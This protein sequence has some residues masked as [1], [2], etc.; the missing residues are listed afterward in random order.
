MFTNNQ[1]GSHGMFS[2]SGKRTVEKFQI[3]L[4]KDEIINGVDKKIKVNDFYTPDN[5]NNLNTEED[6]F[7]VYSNDKNEKSS[8][9]DNIIS[10]N[11]VKVNMSKNKVRTRSYS[12]KKIKKHENP[13]CN[14]YNPN[15]EYGN[16]KLAWGPCWETMKPREFSMIK[17]ERN[18][19]EVHIYN[20]SF[21]I[22]NNVF[23][24]FGKQSNR[25]VFINCKNY[26]LDPEKKQLKEESILMKQK[27][28][29]SSK[30]VQYTKN[31]APDFDKSISR[32]HLDK[33]FGDKKTVIPFSVPKY[34]AVR[35]SNILIFRRKK[36]SKV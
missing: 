28:F 19:N 13:P 12:E 9:I 24:D 32:S 21:N 30:K 4:K 7:K 8:N 20:E 3:L 34:D 29:D 35:P 22:D 1:K 27:K 14:K 16:K 5:I 10:K 6:E 26:E 18:N 2:K 36:S 31:C 23:I 17:S 33:I 11:K 25:K 15:W